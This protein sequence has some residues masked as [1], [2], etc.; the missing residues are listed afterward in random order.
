M[1]SIYDGNLIHLSPDGAS[2]QHNEGVWWC[3]SYSW[4]GLSWNS[5]VGKYMLFV[6]DVDLV[7]KV[8]S[9]NDKE[10]LLMVVSLHSVFASRSRLHLVHEDSWMLPSSS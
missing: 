2:C 1:V 5:M 7:R 3:C 4:K 9:E 8:L 10:T 6:T